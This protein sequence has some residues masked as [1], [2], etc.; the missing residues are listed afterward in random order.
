MN[1]VQLS[2]HKSLDMHFKKTSQQ[3]SV[4]NSE[5]AYF[6]HSIFTLLLYY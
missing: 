6:I 3:Q 1:I 4:N 5:S 2:R